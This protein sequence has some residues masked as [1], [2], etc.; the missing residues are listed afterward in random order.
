V[1]NYYRLLGVTETSSVQE[2]KKAFRERAKR[3]HPD[4]AGNITTSEMRR[5]IT[6]YEALSNQDRRFEYDRAYRRFVKKGEFDYRSYLEEH[7][8]EPTY[9]ARLI[10]FDLLHLD[11]DRALMSWRNLGGVNFPLKK[12]LD[13]EDWMDCAFILAEELEKRQCY[14]DAFMLLVEIIRE[15]RRRPYFKHFTSE[16]E[17]V[18]KELTRLR[19]K[20]VVDE[21]TYILCMENLLSLGFSPRD[22]ARWLCCMAE[23]LMRTGAKDAARGVFKEAMRRDPGLPNMARLRR[24]FNY[25]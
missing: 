23:S 24:K 11:E 17:T 8:D 12:Y 16:V 18:L 14:Y 1:E 5:L 19:L 20:P 10:F 7:S 25:V 6:A 15:E 2:I 22:E 9:Q 21:E 3:L 13:R 4:I